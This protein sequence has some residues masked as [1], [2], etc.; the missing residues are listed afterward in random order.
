M[1]TGLPPGRGIEGM[2]SWDFNTA[3]LTAIGVQIVFLIVYLVKTN[4]RANAAFELADKALKRADEAHEKIVLANA[5]VS[6]LREK[7]AGEHPDHTALAAMEQRLIGEIHSL[8]D[9]L[10][11]I[12]DGRRVK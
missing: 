8:R 7:V 5:G 12:V 2:F 10:D 1:P 3:T 6:M 11:Q 4:G 9:R